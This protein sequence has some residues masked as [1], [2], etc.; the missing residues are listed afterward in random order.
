[1][2][3][4]SDAR[5]AVV[6]WSIE[7]VEGAIKT[8]GNEWAHYDARGIPDDGM[9]GVLDAALERLSIRVMQLRTRYTQYL[10]SI[11]FAVVDQATGK[12]Q[13]EGEE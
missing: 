12:A 9:H 2:A 6:E 7:D 8:F 13:K 11:A 1:M 3:V 5:A 4:G 10:D